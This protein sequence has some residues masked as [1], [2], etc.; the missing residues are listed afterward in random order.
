MLFLINNEKDVI[1]KI[2]PNDG[3]MLSIPSPVI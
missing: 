3:K 1:A 2:I